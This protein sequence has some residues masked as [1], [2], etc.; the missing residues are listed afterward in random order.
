MRLRIF[1]YGTPLAIQLV[2]PLDSLIGFEDRAS[3]PAQPSAIA[4]FLAK[5]L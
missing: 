5:M 4:A 1:A 2:S 3:T